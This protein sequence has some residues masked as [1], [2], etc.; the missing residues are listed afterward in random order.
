MKRRIIKDNQTRPSRTIRIKGFCNK[1][2]II[3]AKYSKDPPM[4]GQKY[5]YTKYKIG[6][7]ILI[8]A[9]KNNGR[10]RTYRKEK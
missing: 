10:K 4:P 6:D 5:E 7:V 9:V 8:K 3:I 1:K 2:E